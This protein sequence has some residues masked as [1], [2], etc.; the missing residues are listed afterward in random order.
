MEKKLDGN[1]TIMLRAILKKSPRQHPIKQQVYGHLPPI[2]KTIKIRRTSHEGHCWKSRDE[3]I[4]DV[5]LWTNSHGQ[6]KAG[7]PART[8]KLDEHPVDS[9]T[10]TRKG[11]TTS[12]NI[13]IRRINH[14]G[15]CWK[16]RDEL[17][18]DVLLWTSSNGQAKA[19]RPA[20]TAKLDELGMRDTAG[21]VGTSS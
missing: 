5:L 20:R 11:R 1:Y 7:R 12:S 6:A 21:K 10:W 14:G 16:S 17:I 8:T 18:S 9:I 19:G 3:L 4:S 15:R 2:M 13:Q